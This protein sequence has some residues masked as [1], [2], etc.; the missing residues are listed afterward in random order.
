MEYSIV[1]LKESLVGFIRNCRAA[2][3]IIIKYNP[4]RKVCTSDLFAAS[5]VFRSKPPLSAQKTL[6]A[7][8][9]PTR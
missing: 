2:N 6:P 5:K 9:F 1:M 7:P 8:F 4:Q 3:E